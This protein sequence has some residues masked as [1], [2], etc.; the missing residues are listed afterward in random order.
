MMYKLE[1]HERAELF[2]GHLF[3]NGILHALCNVWIYHCWK[4]SP[5]L[6]LT[7][8]QLRLTEGFSHHFIEKLS[9][10]PE[11]ISHIEPD[12]KKPDS[13]M[14]F[15]PLMVSVELSVS[16]SAISNLRH[17][18]SFGKSP[19]P[20]AFPSR[21]RPLPWAQASRS[22]SSAGD[23][24]FSQTHLSPSGEGFVSGE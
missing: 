22:V 9:L 12:Q 23:K 2:G 16:G 18:H 5:Q 4:I 17:V 14:I 3:L 1:F 10:W 13:I 11:C 21:Q 8:W 7:T 19:L 24:E 15:L 20:G 6:F